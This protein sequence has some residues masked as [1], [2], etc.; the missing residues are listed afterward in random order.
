MMLLDPC[1]SYAQAVVDGL[2]VAG[3]WVRA[4]CKR[5]LRDL[6]TGAAR[7]LR[8]HLPAAF[9]VWAF[10]EDSLKLSEGQFDGKPFK[11]EPAQYFILGSIFGWQ[12]LNEAGRWVR[13]FRR[14]YI[15]MGKGNGKSPLVGGI[16]LYGMI[17]DREP[18]AQIYSAGATRDQADILFQDAVKMAQQSPDIWEIITPSGNAAVLML[19]AHEPP[20]NHSFFK[21]LSREKS[22]TGSGPRPHMALCDELHEHPDGGILEMLER[23]FKFREQPIMIM[24]TN[25]GSD[26]KS[27]CWEEHEHAIQVATGQVQDDS[28]FSYVCALDEGDDPFK[29]ERCWKKANPLLGVILTYEYLRGVVKQAQDLPSKQNNILRLHFC[30]WT[31]SATAWLPRA[32]LEACEDPDMTLDQFAGKRCHAGLDLSATKD[33][34]AKALLFDDGSKDMVDPSDPTRM[35]RKPCYALFVRAYTPEE[36]LAERAK[37]DKAPYQVWVREGHLVATPGPVIRLDFVAADLVEDALTFDLAGVAYDQHLIRQFQTELDELGASHIPMHDHPQGISR[38][39]GNDLWMPGS[40][41]MFEN[42]VLEQ[43]IRIQVS[44]VLRSAIAGATFWTSPAG[45]KRF[46]KSKATARID[47]CVAAAMAIGLATLGVEQSVSVYDR[48]GETRTGRVA[49][50]E[51][52]IAAGSEIDYNALTDP[53]HPNHAI[54]VRRLQRLEEADED[55][56]RGW[57]RAS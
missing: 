32:K 15:E 13:R 39:Q 27:V 43:R 37:A 50:A 21:P 17:D 46:E 57:R 33:L 18:G 48:R 55:D 11:L 10:F 3:P 35:V 56:E 51:A 31:D 40:V 52:A 24:I 34:T 9:K 45:L 44:P 23:G 12:K 42:L 8:F 5:H 4:A 22:R 49:A 6:Q 41:D 7:N 28:L 25:S 16:G 47:P 38:R 53:K 1:T 29:D 36:T 54:M 2:E 14:A 26:R 20:Q 30:V 19:A